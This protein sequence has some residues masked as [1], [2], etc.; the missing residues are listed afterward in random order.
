MPISPNEM[1]KIVTFD[2]TNVKFVCDFVDR[3]LCDN[4]FIHGN[5]QLAPSGLFFWEVRLPSKSMEGKRITVTDIAE[6]VRL[7]ASAGWS[8]VEKILVPEDRDD[9]AYT[10]I[11]LYTDKEMF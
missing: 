2:E 3:H 8:D 6:I 9:P 11:R 10:S 7:Y 1:Q 5:R 4:A